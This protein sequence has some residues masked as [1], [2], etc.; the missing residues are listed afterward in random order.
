MT[1][2]TLTR[3]WAKGFAAG[4]VSALKSRKC[5]IIE[6]SKFLCGRPAEYEI[7]DVVICETHARR[8]EIRSSMDLHTFDLE[9][10]LGVRDLTDPFTGEM[11]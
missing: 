8:L 7:K 3:A 9:H 6:S 5:P 11:V 1:D 2:D 10:D 4:K